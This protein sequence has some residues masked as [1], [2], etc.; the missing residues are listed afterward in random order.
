[1]RQKF[2]GTNIT[3]PSNSSSLGPTLRL[4]ITD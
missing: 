3:V 4:E 1:M 2:A